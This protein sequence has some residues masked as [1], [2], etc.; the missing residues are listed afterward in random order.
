MEEISRWSNLQAIN[1]QIQRR[2]Q[3]A[4]SGEICVA[5]FPTRHTKHDHERW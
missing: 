4:G 1:E 3:A 5:D 2:N